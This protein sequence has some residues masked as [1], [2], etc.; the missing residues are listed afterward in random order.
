MQCRFI[1]T[2]SQILCILVFFMT[3]DLLLDRF[4]R[5]F[6]FHDC[7]YRLLL[8][9]RFFIRK[10]ILRFG[11]TGF[12]LRIDAGHWPIVNTSRA[13]KVLLAKIRFTKGIR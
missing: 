5:F 7:V 4:F 9:N 6:C 8:S 12:T 13:L 1:D 2:F 11:A 3:F 10:R